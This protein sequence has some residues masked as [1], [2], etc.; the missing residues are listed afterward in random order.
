MTAVLFWG[1][2]MELK[3]KSFTFESR[4]YV[5]ALTFLDT[6]SKDMTETKRIF[7]LERGKFI[8]RGA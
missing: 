1:K 4:C 8:A 5:Y 7:M 2:T 6:K 3:V